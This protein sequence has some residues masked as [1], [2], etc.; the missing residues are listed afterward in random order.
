[1]QKKKHGWC[2]LALALGAAVVPTHAAESSHAVRL[3]QSTP[4]CVAQRLGQVSVSVG[5]QEP[6]P[7]TGMATGSASYEKAFARLAEA[8]HAKGGNAVVLRGHQADYVSK[9]TRPARRPTYVALQG[10]VVVLDGTVPDCPLALVDPSE[11]ERRATSRQRNEVQ[12][13][14][15]VSF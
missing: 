7:R 5:S 2:W 13:D 8:A 3:L 1:M 9:G 14:K 11:F 6:N 10:A 4:A 12:E 15:G